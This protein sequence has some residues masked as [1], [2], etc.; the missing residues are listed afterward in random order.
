MRPL[1]GWYKYM[2][3]YD[4][5]KVEVSPGRFRKEYIFIS[6]YR[7]FALTSTQFRYMKLFYVLMA[8]VLAGLYFAAA[9]MPTSSTRVNLASLPAFV[10]VVPVVC[11]FYG[12]AAYIMTPQR[13]TPRN[14]RS[15]VLTTRY[16]ALAVMLCMSISTIAHGVFLWCSQMPFEGNDLL[17]FLLGCLASVLS[18]AIFAATL[19]IRIELDYR[20]RQSIQKM[21]DSSGN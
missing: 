4:I 8:V 2:E 9:T 21:P 14:Y 19:V 7:V 10:A 3:G 11:L 13:M 20:D 6:D 1:S 16:S 17:Y 12:V 5:R 18:A 15:S